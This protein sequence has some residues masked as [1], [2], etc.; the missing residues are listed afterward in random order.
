MWINY[1]I[2]IIDM[3]HIDFTRFVSILVELSFRYFYD[4]RQIAHLQF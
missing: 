2:L 4:V 1:K 3:V